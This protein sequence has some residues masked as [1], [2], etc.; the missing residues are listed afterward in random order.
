MVSE[1]LDI[2]SGR[3]GCDSISYS[4]VCFIYILDN[5]HPHDVTDFVHISDN[6]EVGDSAK[7][8]LVKFLLGV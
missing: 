1:G 4:R 3:V 6:V 8:A 5:V 2:Y 7:Q